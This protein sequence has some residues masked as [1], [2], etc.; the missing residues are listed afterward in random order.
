MTGD[1]LLSSRSLYVVVD[2]VALHV[3]VLLAVGI[4]LSP[5]SYERCSSIVATGK[6]IRYP[7]AM[8]AGEFFGAHVMA[9]IKAIPLEVEWDVTL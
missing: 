6:C 5:V 9:Y 4:A 2:D 1:M 8:F 7:V 3:S